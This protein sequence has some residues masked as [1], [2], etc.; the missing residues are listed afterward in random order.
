MQEWWFYI[1]L[2]C[3]FQIDMM[4]SQTIDSQRYDIAKNFPW[5]NKK[6]IKKR[7]QNS[8]GPWIFLCR[9]C[10]HGTKLNDITFCCIF[11]FA[12]VLKHDAAFIRWNNMNGYWRIPSLSH[13]CYCSCWSP[14]V[15]GRGPMKSQLSVGQHVSMSVG[16]LTLL[17]K[18][19]CSW[20]FF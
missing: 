12:R 20:D 2:L 19:G 8:L 15:R 5:L 4:G 14:A 3:C 6:K 10:V 11:S 13:L 9:K 16:Q 18:N 17:L 1:I 7:F